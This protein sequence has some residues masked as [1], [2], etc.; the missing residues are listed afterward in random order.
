MNCEQEMPMAIISY[1][2]TDHSN[3]SFSLVSLVQGVEE[4]MAQE[5]ESTPVST[6][7]QNGPLGHKSEVQNTTKH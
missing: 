3:D 4:K 7:K 2:I 5:K 1:D 6:E